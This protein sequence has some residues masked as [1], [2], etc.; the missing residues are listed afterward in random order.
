MLAPVESWMPR[1]VSPPLPMT[2]R[3]LSTGIWMVS[4]RG[5]VSRISYAGRGDFAEHGGEDV[6]TTFL[7]LL[8][9]TT[10]DIGGKAL[11]LVVHLKRRDAVGGAA[12]LEVHVAEEVLEALDVGER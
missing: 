7:G 11:G 2:S 3:I 6:G 5:A 4:M 12:D 8:E 1:I 10:E 9:R